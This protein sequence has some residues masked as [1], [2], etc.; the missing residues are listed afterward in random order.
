MVYRR[1]DRVLIR[2]RALTPDPD[3]C[4]DFGPCSA[5][6]GD[7]DP[8]QCGP[9]LVCVNDVGAQYG[10]PA[11]Y[12]VCEEPS[13]ATPGSDD[14]CV[15]RVC[16][17]GE[18]DCDSDVQCAAGLVCVN[19]VGARYGYRSIVDVCEEPSGAT[20][21]SDD[22]C[23]NRACGVGEGDCDGDA[24]CEDGLV[25]VN[26]V[27][28]SYGYRSEVDVCKRSSPTDPTPP[29]GPRPE[30]CDLFDGVNYTYEEARRYCRTLFPQIGIND[31]AICWYDHPVS[32]IGTV[33][34]CSSWQ[35]VLQA[36]NPDWTC[37][38]L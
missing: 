20:P 38:P 3:Y 22:Y 33:C 8:G 34:G 5:G 35:I 18:S 24:Q 12:D 13:R 15:N 31:P 10:L 27:G 1:R 32:S 4:Q 25:C 14:Y 30:M 21:G 28:A 36:R 17:E 6:Q 23:V 26:D 19:D 29:A 16:E 11:H 2:C 7:C 9:G 37:E